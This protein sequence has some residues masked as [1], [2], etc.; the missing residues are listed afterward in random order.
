MC[1]W[2]V[3]T[4]PPPQ[5]IAVFQGYCSFFVLDLFFQ[6]P[7][8]SG[9]PISIGILRSRSVR[10][11]ESLGETGPNASVVGCDWLRT[12][13]PE[14][15]GGPSSVR[16]LNQPNTLQSGG[17]PPPPQGT[18]ARS[19]SIVVPRLAVAWRSTPQATLQH[20]SAR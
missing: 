11:L 6:R 16:T 17:S 5:A 8:L 1:L 14:A 4:S 3:A 9:Q 7:A 18:P 13:D 20:S 19:P 15:L 12:S 2:W 10:H